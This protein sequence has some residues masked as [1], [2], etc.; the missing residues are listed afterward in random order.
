SPSASTKAFLQS[1]IPAPVCFLSLFTSAAVIF[2]AR[3]CFIVDLLYFLFFRFYSFAFLLFAVSCFFFCGCFFFV[4]SCFI[5]FVLFVAI[6]FALAYS[7][8]DG[9]NHCVEN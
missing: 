9:C 1:I 4:F 6:C 2:I 8:F 5:S 7:F 3:K